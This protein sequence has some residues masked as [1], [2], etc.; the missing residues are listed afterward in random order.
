MITKGSLKGERVFLRALEL[1]DLD[2]IY[3]VENNEAVWEV[4]NMSAPL[5]KY[6]LRQ[7][8]ENAHQD[9]YEVRQLRFVICELKTERPLGFVDLFEF[10]P[11]HKRIGVGILIHGIGDRGKG[12]AHEAVA[13]CRDY[14]FTHL[15]VHQVYA[16]I[17]ANNIASIALFEKLGF[18]NS[19]KKK[20]WVFTQ[21]GFKDE[22]IYQYIKDVH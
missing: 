12:F 15:Q 4:S 21:E 6:I 16:T 1:E 19:G 20:D 22:L 14:A 17:T 10:D 18:T 7:Y 5:S 8:L 9:I 13:L 3:Q 2:F 11:R